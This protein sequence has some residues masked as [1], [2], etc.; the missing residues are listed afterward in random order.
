MCVRCEPV[1]VLSAYKLALGLLL[2]QRVCL[3]QLPCIIQK[4]HIRAG[5]VDNQYNY[6]YNLL[7]LQTFAPFEWQPTLWIENKPAAARRTHA[8]SLANACFH[9]KFQTIYNMSHNII[10]QCRD[11]NYQTR[12][13]LRS[14]VITL[15]V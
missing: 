14:G 13:V 6:I 11:R 3:L 15:L 10:M 4:F 5:Y 12:S 9:S 8:S 1:C 2:R 7:F